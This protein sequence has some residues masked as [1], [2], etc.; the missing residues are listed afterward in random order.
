MLKI[1]AMFGIPQEL[2]GSLRN[3]LLAELL[4]DIPS[5]NTNAFGHHV[6]VSEAL[7]VRMKI[8]FQTLGR[9]AYFY[10]L[11]LIRGEIE[12]R[13]PQLLAGIYEGHKLVF[14]PDLV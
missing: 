2:V 1:A 9:S 14:P 8:E 7:G 11:Q 13:G 10:G 12:K 6:L 4:L 3:N 5:S